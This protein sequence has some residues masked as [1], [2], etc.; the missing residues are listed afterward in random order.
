MAAIYEE[1]GGK[2]TNKSERVRVAQK[3]SH[4]RA[5]HRGHEQN[6]EA[7]MNPT[8]PDADTVEEEILDKGRHITSDCDEDEMNG[9]NGGR[10]DD[11][12]L[13]TLTESHWAQLEMRLGPTNGTPFKRQT[14]VKKELRGNVDTLRRWVIE[15]VAIGDDSAD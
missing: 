3:F 15:S 6:R 1:K 14:W 5:R 2:A 4:K 8:S 13:V 11:D 9:S 7:R 10:S 12:S